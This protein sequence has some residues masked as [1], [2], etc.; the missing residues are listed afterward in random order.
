[1]GQRAVLEIG[2]DLFDDRMLA[3]GLTGRDGVQVA[4]REERVKA[5]RV[6][7]GRLFL[8]RFMVQFGDPSHDQA[9]FDAFGFLAGTE[10][11]EGGFGDL[12]GRNPGA[13]VLVSDRVGVV[14]RGPLV[15]GD[16]GDRALDSGVHPRGDRDFRPSA[17]LGG[18]DSV[19]IERAISAQRHDASRRCAAEA[20][21]SGEDVANELAR[22]AGRAR[23]S[24]PQPG[25]DD[26]RR[27]LRRGDD[28]VQSAHSGVA[29]IRALLLICVD[30]FNGVVDIDEGIV[31]DSGDDW[32]D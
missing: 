17:M 27:R 20:F 31:V 13:G 6:E 25:S 12:G 26:D 1:M 5:V 28:A 21:H 14:D 2:I 15:G 7:E 4:C 32:G 24:S 10:R 16:R 23:R 8:V 29:I 9:A 22:A 18:D 3:M 11:G 30:F 19:A